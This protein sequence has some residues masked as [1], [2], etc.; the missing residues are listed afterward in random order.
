MPYLSKEEIESTRHLTSRAAASALGVGKTSV[1]KYRA[2]YSENSVDLPQARILTID[3]E[4]KPGQYYSW[5][6]KADW[7]ASSMMIDSGGM[8]CFAAKWLGEEEVMFFRGEQAVRSAHVL[9]S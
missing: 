1:N 6:P 4:S 9:L 7:I 2:I 8:I 5:G 3:I